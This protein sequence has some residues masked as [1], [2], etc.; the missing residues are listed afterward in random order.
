MLALSFLAAVSSTSAQLVSTGL[1]VTLNDIYYFISP[2]ASGH[3]PLTPS[4]SSLD[5][6]PNVYGFKAVT[7]VQ[8]AVARSELP[9][10]FANWTAIDDVFQPAFSQAV[11]LAGAGGSCVTKQTIADGTSSFV[12]PL[13]NTAIPSGPYFLETATGSLYS[14]YRLYEDFAGAFSEPLLQTP[15][16]KFQVLSAQIPGSASLTVGVPSRIYFTKTPAK[17]LAGVRIGVKDIYALAG[18][19]RSNGNRAWYNLYPASN[20]TGTAI[21]RLIDAGAQIVG[22]QKPS[23]FA[24][25]ETASE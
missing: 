13:N 22:L 8:G 4:L 6:V 19:K 1:S 2:Y 7:V 20:V 18:M 21:Q 10:L 25:G 3:L 17:P 23:Q 9:A 14:V 11:F 12:F 24:N 16:G 5:K 15:E